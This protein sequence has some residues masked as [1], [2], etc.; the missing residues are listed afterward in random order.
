MSAP[1]V[2]PPRQ[3]SAVLSVR[4]L[5]IAFDTDEGRSLA[6]RGVSFDLAAH[7]ILG[8]VGESGSG[9]SVTALSL[10]G[11][12]PAPGSIQSGYVRFRDRDVTGMSQRELRSLRGNGISMIF[13]DPSASL[14]PV[15]R[16][17]TQVAETVRVHQQLSWRESEAKA[18]EL[19][20]QVGI[21]DP[22]ARMREYPFELSGG[23]RQRAMI[24]AAL[25]NEPQIVVADEPTTALD[26][27][28]QAQILELLESLN[29]ERGTAM[30]LI[31]HNMGVIGR[32]C[33]RALVMYA[34]R[35]VEEGP[36]D[37]LFSASAHPYTKGLL[38]SIP[39]LDRDRGQR[40]QSIKG[41]PPDPL[42]QHDGCPFAPRCAWAIDRCRV[43]APTLSEVAPRQRAACW[44]TEAVLDLARTTP[45][46]PSPAPAT[47]DLDG[48]AA[49][50]RASDAPPP[51]SPPLLE[52]ENLTKLFPIRSAALAHRQSRRY[53]RAVEDVSLTLHQGETLGI[54]G[55]SGCGKSTLARTIVR[56]YSP[57]SGQIRLAG[58]DTAQMSE[59]EFRPLRGKLQMIFQDPYGSLNPRMTV[60]QIIAEPLKV[61]QLADGARAA[62]RVDEL[63]LTA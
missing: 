30:I 46:G 11:M 56:V 34:G 38:D 37:Q 49:A 18:I 42:Q 47:A 43:E 53:V 3:E 26:V 10:L 57:T 4:D 60:E 15:V 48:R 17:G 63:L 5:S 27:T 9:K 31:T 62:Q 52:L 44:M 1:P 61:H 29:A 19:L 20:R 36:V 25:V 16:I 50:Q 55:E 6:V 41:Q 40:L 24:A 32:L 12:V 8:I 59:R 33:S 7:E 58:Q 2:V 13:Q 14:N 21:P 54:V 28:I 22:E 51:G 35:I 39:R 23:M 45:A